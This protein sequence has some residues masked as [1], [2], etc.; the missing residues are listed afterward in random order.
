MNIF[1]LHDTDFDL[2]AQYHNNR[3]VVKMIL[4]STQLLNNARI[5]HNPTASHVYRETHKNHPATLWTAETDSNF[6]WLTNLGLALCKEYTYR[7]GKKHKCEDIISYFKESNLYIPKGKLTPFVQCMPDQYK[8]E[9]AA[10]AY[11]NYY[12]GEKRDI[13]KWTGRPIPEWWF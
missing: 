5:K 3:H 1:V 2:C 4:E 11:R 13:A 10:E 7:Y 12:R 6:K 9:N 8:N